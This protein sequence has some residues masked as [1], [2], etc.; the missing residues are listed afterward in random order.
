MYYCIPTRV[1]TVSEMILSGTLFYKILKESSFKI[2]IR[3]KILK[4]PSFLILKNA[5]YF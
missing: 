1:E 5:V 2:L 4:E 3:A